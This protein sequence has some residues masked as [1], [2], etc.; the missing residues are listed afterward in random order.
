MKKKCFNI[1]WLIAVL[2]SFTACNDFLDIQPVG[3]VMPKTGQEFRD[4]L[5]E[6][7]SAITNDRG[8]TVYRSDELILD[9]GSTTSEGL[10]LYLDIWRWK[11]GSEDN[12]TISFGWRTFYYVSY[13]ANTVIEQKDGIT[14]V[15]EAECN[16]LAGEAY[17]LRAYMHFILVNLYAE[18]YTHCD[19]TVTKGIPLKLN[20]DVKAV[21]S[22]NTVGEVYSSI[23]SDINEAEKLLNVETWPE[24]ETYR[25]NKLSVDAFRSRVY[26]YMGDW[27]N[28]YNKAKQVV[29]THGELEDM[30]TSSVLPNHYHSVEAILSLEEVFAAEFQTNGRVS[31]SLLDLYRSGD[32]RKSKF[33][34]AETTSISYVTKGGSNEYRC[35]FRTSEFYLTAAEAALELN[36]MDNAHYYLTELMKKRYHSSRYPTYE[37]LIL[38]MTKD[39]LRQEIYDER[40][41]ELAFEGHRWF[42]LRRTNRP[43]LTKTYDG[44]TYILQKDDER[45]TLRI[46]SEAIQA[47]P[48]LEE[49]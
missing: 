48:G 24:G 16:Q 10:N 22:R 3:K 31:N 28:A 11:D 1:V 47:N 19:P 13:I 8:K 40:F 26:L 35:T 45:Y 17:M 7:Y 43:E 15:S 18:P 37:A 20:S 2:L 5:T 4:L 49:E 32:M 9:K 29:E 14:E 36:D 27:Q 38:S 25:F 41:R 42:D 6:A 30:T 33:Y 21:L 44:E 12:N 34:R 46:P 39:E 23:L